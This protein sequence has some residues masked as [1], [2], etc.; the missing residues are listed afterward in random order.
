MEKSQQIPRYVPQD[1]FPPYAFIGGYSPH[2]FK[3]PEGHSYGMEIS[4]PPAPDPKRW[5]EC[6]DYL[7]GIDLFN[8][9][10]YWEAHEVWEGLWQA[11]GKRGTLATFL[12]GLIKLAAAGVKVRQRRSK[13]VRIH[14]RRAENHFREVQKQLGPAVKYY[15]GLSL[16]ELIAFAQEIYVQADHLAG[17]PHQAVEIVFMTVLQPTESSQDFV[18]NR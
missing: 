18:H 10:Y 17:N 13:G 7:R 8:H 14:S 5:S 11:C 15:M 2:P 9:G 1:P 6:I 16:D 3:H 4:L 12:R